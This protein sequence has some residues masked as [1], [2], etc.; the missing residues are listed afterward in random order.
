MKPV[1]TTAEME[2]VD[3]EGRRQVGLET[4]VARAGFSVARA[5]VACLGGM[6]G[7][8]VAVVA[9]KGHNGDDGRVA[10]A[11]LARRGAR[12]TVFPAADV[13]DEIPGCDLVVDAAFGTRFHGDYRAPRP[14]PEA[15]V[16]AV[17]IPSGVVADTGSAT[18]GAVRA[19]VTVTFGALKPGLL[20]GQG[21]E[22][23]GAVIVEP[24]GL[25]V[26]TPAQHLVEDDDLAWIPR[27]DP[28]GNKWDNAVYVVAGSPGMFGAA[29]LA[30]RGA[31]RA[32]AGMVRLGSPGIEPGTVPVVEAV[33]RPVP[34]VDWAGAVLDELGRCQALV[35]GPGLG[36]TAEAARG[37]LEVVARAEVPIVIDADGLFA[38]GA[39]AE[40]SAVLRR[41][42]AP[43]VLTPHDGEYARLVGAS[44]GEDRLAATRVLARD[45][46]AFVLLKGPATVVAAPS[47]EA[48]I[49]TAGSSRLSTAGTGDVLSGVLGALLARGLAPLQAAGLAAHVHGRAAAIGLGEGLGA[50][51]LPRLV[52][53]VLSAG[54]MGPG[55]RR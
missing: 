18:P 13:P 20:L 53:S 35:V 28:Q 26:G 49:V 8:R 21:P 38:L 36:R 25:E 5:A 32:G 40:A 39:V 16:L 50:S 23:A 11:L 19:D 30:A 42:R 31:I 46:G 9:G 43:T 24:I 12:V 55:S 37:I 1:L 33:A 29:A 2:A 48:L 44:P 52:A 6:Y 47:G 41:R 15:V 34:E 51:D 45:L 10:A 14:P 27:R 17:D 54:G 4:L 7:R 22:L 3:E